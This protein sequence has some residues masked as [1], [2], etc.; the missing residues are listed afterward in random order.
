MV[1]VGC[2]ALRRMTDRAQRSTELLFS[3]G[4]IA[5]VQYADTEDGFNYTGTRQRYYRSSLD[6]LRSAIRDWNR[7]APPPVFVLQLGDIIDGCNSRQKTSARAL[8]AVLAELTRCRCP[9][10]HVW[11]NHEFYNFDRNELLTSALN[12]KHLGEDPTSGAAANDPEGFYSYHFSP[13]PKFRFVLTDTYDLSVL[14]RQNGSKKHQEAL[15]TLREKN[16][17]ENLNSPIGLAEQNFVEFNGGFSREQLEWLNQV[18]TFSDNNQEKVTVV[19]HL[20]VHPNSTDP[21]CV[22]WNYEKILSVLH[23]HQSVVCFISGHDHDGGYFLD[24]HGIHHLT[25]EGVIETPPNSQA[26]GTIYAHEDRMVLV[27]RG[28]VP[29]R[30]LHYRKTG[31]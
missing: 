22:A 21:I 10:H 30:I 31:D 28:R 24:E 19:G 23:A 26:F 2:E 6:L 20:P 13:F 3:F 11:G 12:S 18:L 7:E 4:V 29:N 27:G 17:N 16:K 1:R 15:Q 25:F 5:D 8:R 9:V 14:G